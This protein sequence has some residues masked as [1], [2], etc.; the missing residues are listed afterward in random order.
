LSNLKTIEPGCGFGFQ[1]LNYQISQLLNQV[2]SRATLSAKRKRRGHKC[3]R[4]KSFTIQS[5]DGSI[6]Q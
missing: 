1:F 4:H 5:L 6:A 3:P 2:S